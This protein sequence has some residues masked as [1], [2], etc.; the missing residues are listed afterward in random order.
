MNVSQGTLIWK[1]L[2][3][4]GELHRFEIPN[5]YYVPDGNVRLL[6]PQ[7]WAQAQ[8]DTT[9]TQGTGETTDANNVTLF[10]NQRQ[11]KLTVPIS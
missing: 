9:P 4:A 7:H 8:K 5:S 2:D 3:D 1:W 10:W 6:S 11:N